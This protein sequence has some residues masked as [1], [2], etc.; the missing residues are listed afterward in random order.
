[1]AYKGSRSR[2]LQSKLMPKNPSL[3]VFNALK[4]TGDV[5]H[6]PGHTNLTYNLKYMYKITIHIINIIVYKLGKIPMFVLYI[7]KF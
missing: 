3:N 2:K 5:S 7:I 4:L 1:M 6:W